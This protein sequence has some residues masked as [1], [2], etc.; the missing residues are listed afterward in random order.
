MGLGISVAT[1][2]A[3][4][5]LLRGIVCQTGDIFLFVADPEHFLQ[6]VIDQYHL[7]AF[8][9]VLETETSVTSKAYMLASTFFRLFGNICLRRILTG[10]NTIFLVVP[11]RRCG[12][13]VE[14]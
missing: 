12:D 2:F 14:S 3:E 4:G 11:V 13:E 1:G 10:F 9:I 5:H 8:V 6:V 7:I